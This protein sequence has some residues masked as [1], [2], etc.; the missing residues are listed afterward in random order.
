MPR[1]WPTLSRPF[2]TEPPAFLCAIAHSSSDLR[3]AE[4]LAGAPRSWAGLA[5]AAGFLAARLRWYPRSRSGLGRLRRWRLVGASR[6]RL[7][8]GPSAVALSAFAGFSAASFAASA[9]SCSAWRRAASSSCWRSV[10]S[11][12]LGLRDLLGG[13][14]A[15]ED[16]VADPDDHQL[17]AMALLD[18]AARLRPV[19]EAD[20]LL[21]AVAAKDLARR[22]TRSRRPACRSTAVSPSAMSRTRSNATV[23]PG[24]A[25]RSSISSSVPTST[26]YCFPP[27][28]MTAYMEPLGVL[29]VARRQAAAVWTGKDRLGRSEAEVRDCTASAP[30]RQFAQLSWASLNW[31]WGR[32]ASSGRDR[33]ERR[34][35]RCRPARTPGASPYRSRIRS[36]ATRAAACSREVAGRSAA[37]RS[38]SRHALRTTWRSRC[39]YAPSCEPVRKHRA[40]ASRVSREWGHLQ[41]AAEG[42]PS[43]R[44]PS[45]RG[46]ARSWR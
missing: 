17:L 10:A 38:A 20:E 43:I 40:C 41:D 35:R 15:V 14:L 4:L 11:A 16:D 32:S 13:T 9:A 22:P 19:L 18:A 26:R 12:L 24:A 31:R 28:S 21:A 25:S 3:V 45:R 5:F 36:D 44:M 2:L 42:V 29:V 37:T 34:Q 33:L 27:V 7:C 6:L 46:R 30:E 39:T 8:L 23:S 1:R